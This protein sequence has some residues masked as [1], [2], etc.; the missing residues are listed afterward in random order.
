M[1]PKIAFYPQKGRDGLSP[2]KDPIWTSIRKRLYMVF[3]PRKASV[4]ILSF[5]G[6]RWVSI[7]KREAMRASFPQKKKKKLGLFY[8]KVPTLFASH[9]T[10]ESSHHK[11]NRVFSSRKLQGLLS[12]EGHTS[13][14][15]QQITEFN[16][17]RSLQN[18]LFKKT[19]GSSLPRSPQNSLSIED[20]RTFSHSRSQSYSL[21]EDHGVVSPQKVIGYSI[22]RSLQD[23]P[24]T[25]DHRRQ[26]G[27][28]TADHRVF[29]R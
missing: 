22:D 2:M 25:A 1:R 3:Y 26:E 12:I 13:F 29:C 27:L 16:F 8:T 24:S 6:Q 10:T 28:Y 19:I 20:H 14:S 11:D 21:T 18:C 9:I 15:P 17:H 23:L 7:Q 5:E 4:R